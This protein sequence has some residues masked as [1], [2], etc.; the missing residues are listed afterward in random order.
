MFFNT[1]IIDYPKFRTK[2]EIKQY[3]QENKIQIKLLEDEDGNLMNFIEN[4]ILIY[5]INNDFSIEIIELII[6]NGYY[7]LNYTSY[8]NFLY[9][10]PLS[11][12]LKNNQFDI[13]DLLISYGAQIENIPLITLEKIINI[14]NLKYI[15]NKGFDIPQ[16]LIS[17]LIEADSNELLQLIFLY[18]IK[19]DNNIPSRLIIDLINNYNALSILC[20]NDIRGDTMI[21]DDIS[22][23]FKV[24][25][26][27][28][29]IQYNL[30]HKGN[31]IKDA[32]LIKMKNPKLKY[33]INRKFLNKLENITTYQEDKEAIE[34][35]IENDEYIEFK[36][37]IKENNI[38]LTKF[39]F[40]VFIEKIHNYKKKDIIEFSIMKSNSIQLVN[41]IIDLCLKEDPNIVNKRY[42]YY[43]FSAVSSNKFKI[44]Y[45]L[46]EKFKGKSF[47]SLYTWLHKSKTLNNE[48]LKFLLI[49]DIYFNKY[50][51][52]SDNTRFTTP[53]YS[54]KYDFP[55]SLNQ[56]LKYYLFNNSFILK[57]LSYYKDKISLSKS[58]FNDIVENEKNKYNDNW[59]YQYQLVFQDNDYEN[60]NILYKYDTREKHIILE[61]LFNILIKMDKEVQDTF[62]ENVKMKIIKLPI[63][64]QYIN[65]LKCYEM[66]K[67]I[68]FEMI[69]IN[70]IE[71]LNDLITKKR[72]SLDHFNKY[73]DDIL[74]YAINHD[75]SMNMIKFIISQYSTLNYII[76]YANGKSLTD[77]LY[78]QSVPSNKLDIPYCPLIL[79]VILN[80]F[81][82]FK[83][84]LEN[85]A[86][87][88]YKFC[89][90]NENYNIVTYLYKNKLLNIKNLKFI[91]NNGF[92]LL[93]ESIS[94][95]IYDNHD[96]NDNIPNK[97]QRNYYYYTNNNNNDNNYNNHE[98][99]EAHRF[100]TLLFENSIFD[101]NFI[102]K[103]LLSS[104][105]KIALSDTQ[106]NDIILKEKNKIIMNQELFD[107]IYDNYN[108]E[109]LEMFLNY[110]VNT[111][112]PYTD[113]SDIYKF[114]KGDSIFIEYLFNLKLLNYEQFSLETFIKNILPW[115]DKLEISEYEFLGKKHKKNFRLD[116]FEGLKVFLEKY[117]DY[118][119]DFI[120]FEKEDFS[121]ILSRLYQ[122]FYL[123]TF[124]D[125]E[126]LE[127]FEFLR[128]FIEKLLN[129][130]KFYFSHF[131]P[132]LLKLCDSNFQ[133]LF[134]KKSLLHEKFDL[135]KINIKTVLL[136]LKGLDDNLYI[137]DYFIN[138]LLNN[139]H[140][141][142][143]INTQEIT[144]LSNKLKNSL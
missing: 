96:N 119:L 3:F 131:E 19:N 102:L 46:L 73:N 44:S 82:V 91:L 29:D 32:F 76:Y 13:A 106:L 92:N 50:D 79:S 120:D 15:I 68:I 74:A 25:F 80:K 16:Q 62:V 115:D 97:R 78:M 39:K 81:E 54:I 38:H 21:L 67:D 56:F 7:T 1:N 11:S 125:I 27:S 110:D 8:S 128:I 20:N 118:G 18:L 5:C 41:Y 37:Y 139:N 24:D 93:S 113:S 123:S 66:I 71:K 17:N 107:I 83:I 140:I 122:K 89:I 55:F 30:T 77:S 28:R 63:D 86:D 49:S 127:G 144:L 121:K 143:S 90:A 111:T 40:K 64:E 23:I 35:Y 65:N 126:L 101:N 99:N 129:S 45:F 53:L 51:I 75:A 117:I 116:H 108:Y 14:E 135:T 133:K 69:K 36:K 87:I 42:G 94:I 61:D 57:L 103:L 100:L 47:K 2:D 31:T 136:F 60:M 52:N 109:V 130:K 98:K 95:F 137:F 105:D 104:K 10:T 142:N 70:Q 59:S 34:K 138:E 9:N 132:N 22:S 6:I 84:L 124:Y 134:I 58:E 85:G 33:H 26:I 72:I 112:D 114:L 141:K 88:N 43:I 48:N 4:D 12:A